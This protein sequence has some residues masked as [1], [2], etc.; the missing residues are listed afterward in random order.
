[1]KL[2]NQMEKDLSN[3]ILPEDFNQKVWKQIQYKRKKN[4][5]NTCGCL[6]LCTYCWRDGKRPF[7]LS[8]SFG[9]S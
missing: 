1:M 6:F 4:K 8:A 5:K 2:K 3:I 7:Y 9:K